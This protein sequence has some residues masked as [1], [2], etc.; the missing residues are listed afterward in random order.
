MHPDCYCMH[1]GHIDGLFNSQ[2][3]M[4]NV[5]MYNTVLALMT[6]VRRTTVALIWIMSLIV[7]FSPMNHSQSCLYNKFLLLTVYM[8][9]VA[10]IFF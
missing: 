7:R 5:L 3:E 1:R 10:M 6:G 9:Q 2:S 8:Y 4:W